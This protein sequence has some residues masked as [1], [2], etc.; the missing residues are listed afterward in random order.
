MNTE[1]SRKLFQKASVLIPGGVN[2]PVRACKSVDA[3]PL[4][5]E[6]AIGCF[7]Y[8]A[9]GNRYIDYVGSWGPMILGHRHSVVIEAIQKV[10]ASGETGI[11]ESFLRPAGIAKFGDKRI[12]VLSEGDF[13]EQGE[14]I[15][16][17]RVSGNRVVVRK[18]S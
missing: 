15:V 5:I 16:I 7:V 13:I 10:L 6:S 4:F 9:D 17:V 1:K 2:S 3:D 8:D 18:S 11:A 14:K 12:D